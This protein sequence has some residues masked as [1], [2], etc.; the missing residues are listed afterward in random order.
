MTSRRQPLRYGKKQLSRL[1]LAVS[2]GRVEVARLRAKL[3]ANVNAADPMDRRDLRS[4]TGRVSADTLIEAGA[5]IEASKW[6]GTTPSKAH[7]VKP[8]TLKQL[9]LLS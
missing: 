4:A 9:V 1:D 6:D 8:P 7:R 5:D 3:G 2:S